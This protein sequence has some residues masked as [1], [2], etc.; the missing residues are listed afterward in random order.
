MS[1]SEQTE[2]EKKKERENTSYLMCDLFI[3]FPKYSTTLLKKYCSFLGI[4]GGVK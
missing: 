2:I 4:C 3:F 1:P